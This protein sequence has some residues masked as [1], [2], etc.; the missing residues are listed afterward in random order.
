MSLLKLVRD[1]IPEKII[2]SWESPDFYVANKQEYLSRLIDKVYEEYNEVLTANENNIIEELWD[3][4]ETII[5]ILD[6]EKWAI[7]TK[8]YGELN[9]VIN[10]VLEIIREK[11]IDEV[12][13][14]KSRMEKYEK[15]GWFKKKII[16][17]IK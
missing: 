7:S 1:K 5:S 9:S 2:W 8:I 14:E 12:D 11:N 13:I 15:Y 4:K 17:K 6:I 10:H 16:L 3:F